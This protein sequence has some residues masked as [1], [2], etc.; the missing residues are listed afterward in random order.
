MVDKGSSVVGK[1]SCMME[2]R[3]CV[4][5]N[6]GSFNNWSSFNHRGSSNKRSSSIVKAIVVSIGKAIV[7]PQRMRVSNQRVVINKGAV[8]L[9]MSSNT[10]VVV[11][12]GI[13]LGIGISI[14]FSLT[15]LTCNNGCCGRSKRSRGK[16]CGK[17]SLQGAASF[18]DTVMGGQSDN[19]GH[20]GNRGNR[21][22]M[23]DKRGSMMNNRGVDERSSMK[24]RSSMNFMR[25]YN[26][27]VYNRVSNW[28]GK[29]SRGN[30]RSNCRSCKGSS[31]WSY[32][33]SNRGSSRKVKASVEDQLRISL[34]LTFMKMNTVD[35]LVAT[36]KRTSI[37]RYTSN[38]SVEVWVAIGSIV[39]QGIGFRLSQ[40]ER[41]YGENYDHALHDVYRTAV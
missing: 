7:I 21:S 41:G 23:M 25:N 31:S 28:E 15:T 18:C 5:N 39:V 3:G 22:N 37:A 8:S 17:S 24:K 33:G 6:R 11:S 2:D 26:W 30:K 16:S 38:W 20:W 34:S 40:A 1:R 10:A 32:K 35:G 36:I 27:C 9:T 14:S 29:G 12:I 13:S 4:V 19:W